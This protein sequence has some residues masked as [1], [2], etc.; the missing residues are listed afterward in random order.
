M[1]AY[2]TTNQCYPTQSYVPLRIGKQS[3]NGTFIGVGIG[4]GMLL[5]IVVLTLVGVIVV[6]VMVKRRA[7]SKKAGSTNMKENPSYYNPVVVE[8]EV[9]SIG[10]DYEDVDK[11]KANG[12]I[13]PDFDPYEDVETK[14][15]IKNTKKKKSNK[16][17]P[18]ESCTPARA[19]NVGE[20]Y[21]VVDKSKKKG[22]RQKQEEDGCTVTNK[23]D[24][25]TVPMKKSKMTDEGKATSGCAVKSEDYDDVAELKYKPKVDSESGQLS[26]ENSEPL[27]VDMLYAVVDKSHK[28]QK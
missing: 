22:V 19:T 27:K 8:L 23:D 20:L 18:K 7:A 2:C 17:V 16:P 11:D 25:Y 5:L 21:A 1:L 14:A 3:G 12:S 26:E 4:I 28:K 15:Q 6:V 9:K 24:L 10:A 13:L